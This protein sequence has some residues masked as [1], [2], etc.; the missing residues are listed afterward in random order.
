MLFDLSLVSGVL[1]MLSNFGW[2]F[3]VLLLDVVDDVDVVDSSFFVLDLVSLL[4]AFLLLA[5]TPPFALLS[6]DR[7]LRLVDIDW[8]SED[9]I[10]DL[11]GVRANMLWECDDRGPVEGNHEDVVQHETKTE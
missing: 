9:R 11:G 8:R 6:D 10:G 5:S 4:F 2:V 3:C 7:E 1:K